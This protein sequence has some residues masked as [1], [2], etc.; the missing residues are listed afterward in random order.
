M[1]LNPKTAKN[2]FKVDRK[3]KLI[4]VFPNE[5]NLL[6]AIYYI[7]T[8]SPKSVENIFDK[9]IIDI[10]NKGEAIN[11]VEIIRDFNGWSWNNVIEKNLNK[12]YNLIY[13]NLLILLGNN[14]LEEIIKAN[15]IRELLQDKFKIYNTG[16]L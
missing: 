16:S 13:Q 12:Y 3:N 1:I 7:N 2:K 4:K 11:N 9:V 5:V 14:N 10:I 6:Q 8:Q 15:N